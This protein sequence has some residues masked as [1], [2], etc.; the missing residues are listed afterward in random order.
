MYNLIACV[1]RTIIIN[2][3]AN[4]TLLIPSNLN[5]DK[6]MLTHTHHTYSTDRKKGGTGKMTEYGKE[7]KTERVH[8]K[9]RTVRIFII[10]Q[11]QYKF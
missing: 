5:R 9:T 4:T 8:L 2:I 11:W 6:T 10:P 1:H 3:K 7:S